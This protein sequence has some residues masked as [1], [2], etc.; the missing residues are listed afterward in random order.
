MTSLF[1]IVPLSNHSRL[2]LELWN[3][4]HFFLFFTI[5]FCWLYFFVLKKQ[6][7][8]SLFS[9]IFICS[10]LALLTE[11]IQLKIPGRTFSSVD[12]IKDITGSAYAI[13]LFL[14]LKGQISKV[15]FRLTTLALFLILGITPIRIMIENWSANSMFPILA[16][17][18]ASIDSSKWQTSNT[19]VSDF[20]AAEGVRSLKVKVSRDRKYSGFGLKYFPSNWKGYKHLELSIFVKRRTQINMNIIDQP[21]FATYSYNDRFNTVLNL[22]KGWNYIV[23]PLHDIEHSPSNRIMDMSKIKSLGFFS[24]APHNIDEFYLDNIHLTL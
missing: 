10:L 17:F 5:S 7:N 2:L 12:I 16:N 1:M 24:K 8:V 22:S 15:L 11:L 13:M 9:F 3:L 21:H 14:M 23:I 6:R 4:G 20:V 19:S 18:E